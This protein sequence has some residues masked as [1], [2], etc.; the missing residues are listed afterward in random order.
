VHNKTSENFVVEDFFYTVP[1]VKRIAGKDR[2]EVSANLSKENYP[3]G[4]DTVV[5]ARG[6]LYTDALSGGALASWNRAPILLTSTNS[7]PAS[8]RA[9]ITRLKASHAIILGGTGSVSKNVE[10]Q[11]KQ[12]G[13]TTERYAGKNR[14]DVSAQIA[15]TI[16]QIFQTDTA[17][18]ASGL[19]F[20]DALSASSPSG[21]MLMPILLVGT[22]S[23][24]AE[25]QTFLKKNKNVKNFI[26]VGGPATVSTAVQKKLQSYGH[27][28]R[29]SGKNRFEVGVNLIKYFSDPS[30]TQS[31]PELAFANGLNFPDAL[32]GGPFAANQGAPI[33]LTQPTKLD[34]SVNNFLD[35]NNNDAIYIFGGTASVSTS[36]E[37]K[38]DSKIK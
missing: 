33:L 7:L 21:Q 36:V 37:K 13:L 23:V 10:D 24:P 30:A 2:F 32:S 12:M 17:I 15:T 35:H 16:S 1:G 31:N 18:V 4:T 3:H 19:N 5:I 26:I 9:E 28:D 8:I 11:L 29:V 14:F 22:N 38:L 34:P 27:V 25:I 6:D 20:P